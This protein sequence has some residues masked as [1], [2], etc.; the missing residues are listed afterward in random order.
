MPRTA[1]A[2]ANAPLILFCALAAHACDLPR[3]PADP[4]SLSP[5]QLIEVG[6]D[7]LAKAALTPILEADPQNANAAWLLSRALVD[8]GEL[9]RALQFAERAVSL[10]T[11]NAAYHVQLGAVLGRVAEK[12]SMF[13]QLGLARR[14]RKELEAAV[15]LDPRNIDGLLGMMHYYFSAPSFLGGDKSKAADYAD[16]ISAVDAARGWMAKAALA[17]EQKD[18]DAELDRS[19]HAV[20]ADPGNFD[21]QSE[22]AQYYLDR[23]QPDYSAAEQRACTL[24]ELDPGRPDGWRVMAAVHAA[25]H[26]WTEL[27]EVLQLSE[28]F[29]HEDLSPHYSAAAVM[30][31]EGERLL[32]AQSY[33]EKYLSQPPE[34]S[35]PSHAMARCQLATLLEREQHPDE[36][37]AQLNLALQEDPSLEAAKKD[38]KRLKGK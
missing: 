38:L 23:P 37:V 11:D 9:D 20:A 28:H 16:R 30:V 29:N 1:V 26:C 19:L 14:T 17:R 6:H 31:R 24:L 21:A 25:S 22:L 18:A 7:I 4:S 13:K 10:D 36:A 5:P 32:V 34:G 35:E 2:P 33:L 8:L 3:P 12:A 27:D 15:A